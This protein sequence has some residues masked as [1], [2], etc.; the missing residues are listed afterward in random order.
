MT[1]TVG[2]SQ[3]QVARLAWKS[4]LPAMLELFTVS[5]RETLPRVLFLPMSLH[6]VLPQKDVE[7]LTKTPYS[8]VVDT[9]S[10]IKII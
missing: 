6:S 1:T 4:P 10:P 7:K 9:V 8:A 5:S 3:T 2:F